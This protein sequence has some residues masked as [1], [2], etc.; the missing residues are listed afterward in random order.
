MKKILTMTDSNS[1]ITPLEAESLGVYVLPMPFDIDGREYLENIDLSQEDFYQMLAG[2]A[3]VS[4]SQP[5]PVAITETW[6]RLL[7]ENDE[8]VYIPMSSGLSGS[9]ATATM[10]VEDYEGRVQVVNNHRI[11]VTQ[12]QS[13]LDS[14]MLSE[15]G[16]SADEIKETLEMHALDPSIYIM[17][18]TLKY[19]KKGGRISPAAA[20][21][22][23]LLKIKPVLQIQGE[24]LDSYAKARTL[25]HAK[26]I[27]LSAVRRDM[28]EKYGEALTDRDVLISGAYTPG[29]E[30]D[31]WIREVQEAFP[32]NEIFMC[33]LPL[34]ISCHIGTG[35]LAITVTKKL[36]I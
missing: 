26:S 14:L 8:I 24:K 9:C 25:K 32:E 11:S 21:L 5:S 2:G 15:K 18:D 1:S 20:A 4:T 28:A 29:A 10:L 7:E 6:D 19:L 23:S 17:V 30:Y 27:M 31:E 12:R 13:V 22:G 3:E 33:P 16:Y 35:A 36:E 34:S